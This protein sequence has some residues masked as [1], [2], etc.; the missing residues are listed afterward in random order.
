MDVVS[1]LCL[2]L[3]PAFF[4]FELLLDFV[5]TVVVLDA[6]NCLRVLLPVIGLLY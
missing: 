1:F 5:A 3:L 2:L 6:E 4:F